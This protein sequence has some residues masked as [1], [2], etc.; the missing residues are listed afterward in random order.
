MENYEGRISS[1][2]IGILL[3]MVVFVQFAV[4]QETIQIHAKD[5]VLNTLKEQHPRLI[6]TER[7]EKMK[8]VIQEDELAKKIWISNLEFAEELLDKKPL[9]YE[10]P[11][12]RRLLSVSREALDRV[13]PPKFRTVS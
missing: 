4:A 6:S 10:K 1:R 2:W 8:E 3:L 5:G 12:G 9:I 13:L 11:D 7:V